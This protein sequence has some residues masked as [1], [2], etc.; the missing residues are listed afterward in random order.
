MHNLLKKYSLAIL[1]GALLLSPGVTLATN[2]TETFFVDVA[3][4]ARSRGE[5]EALLMRE[6]DHAYFY[7]EKSYWRGLSSEE[8]IDIRNAIKSLASEFDENIYPEVTSLWGSEWKPGIDDD[9]KITI[10]ISE[11]SGSVG[12]YFNPR[13]QYHLEERSRSNER[14]MLYL[15]VSYLSHF[16]VKSFM[17]H[18]FQHLISHNHKDRLRGFSED[19]WLND[20]RSEYTPTYLGYDDNYDTSNLKYRISAFLEKP[21]DPLTDWYNSI[22]DY[23]VA[24][25]F[26][27]Y[28]V[29]HYSNEVLQK[30]MGQDFPGIA[31]INR[32][33]RDA[34]FNTSFSDVFSDWTVANFVNNPDYKDGLYFYTTPSYLS[35]V[36]VDPSA[37]YAVLPPQFLIT[38]MGVVKE[39]APL[40]YEFKSSQAE[41][42]NFS[43][44][45][46]LQ[47]KPERGEVQTRI[48]KFKED[49]IKSIESLELQ[50]NKGEYWI[51]NFPDAVD[52]VVVILFN[53]YEG[54]YLTGGLPDEAYASFT[55]KVQ[56]LKAVPQIKKITSD[57]VLNSRDLVTVS[58]QFLD[59]V[60]KIV[61]DNKEITD[62]SVQNESQL[63]FQLPLFKQ[64][65]WKDLKLIS[66]QETG[67]QK[68]QALKI[69]EVLPEGSLA[70]SA[71]RPEVYII[72]GSFKRHI[73]NSQIFS[74]YPHLDWEQ[75]SQVEPAALELYRESFLIRP[76]DSKKVY[77]VNRNGTKHW[78]N[79]SAQEFTKSGRSW[80]AVYVVNKK[81]AEFYKTGEPVVYQ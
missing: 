42:E 75:L 55:L 81:E 59:R 8:D 20:V 43:L 38:K 61:V 16:R 65:G 63:Q 29:N 11:L 28:L 34:G 77:E 66:K 78:L 25:L 64:E 48:L 14:E 10:L 53:K 13:D 70:R 35:Q 12:G 72:K 19:N 58:G 79:M 46:S 1:L 50:D 57:Y 44:K 56:S 71:L 21:S 39:W 23:G 15:N 54:R 60:E 51:N 47:A 24:N 5:V 18:E 68:N 31:S 6:S 41:E 27:Q 36:K 52:K 45:L 22:Y 3:Y 69:F 4:D 62:F 33:L 7:L 73:L 80:D 26:G 40:W 9:A 76:A 2:E 37:S 30:T 74:F 49:E 17:A 67:V 32:S